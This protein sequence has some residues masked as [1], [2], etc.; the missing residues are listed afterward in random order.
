MVNYELIISAK[1]NTEPICNIIPKF[2]KEYSCHNKIYQNLH[3]HKKTRE[4]WICKK[5]TPV[6]SLVLNIFRLN[7][8]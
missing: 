1:H 7:G 4:V 3:L 6:R 2:V 5:E 8:V